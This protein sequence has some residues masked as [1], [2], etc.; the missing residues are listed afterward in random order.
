LSV[1]TSVALGA[2]VPGIAAAPDEPAPQTAV[3]RYHTGLIENDPAAVRTALG[4][5]FLMF[6]G[7]FSGEPTAWQAHLY[8][9]GER[10]DRWPAL[11]LKEAGPYE[12]RFEFL[13]AHVRGDAAVVVTRET[14]KN[15]FRSWRGETVTW[16]LGRSDGEW[17]IVGFFIRDI[18][19]PE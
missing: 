8:L 5:E 14:G 19:N 13:H 2:A 15:R 1:L 17:K 12:N 4:K 11:F 6:N 10:L 7:N 3:V 18:R 16:L 9:T